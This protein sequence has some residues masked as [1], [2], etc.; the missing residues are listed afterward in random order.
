[1]DKIFPRV[2]RL[3]SKILTRNRLPGYRSHS[4]ELL[5]LGGVEYRVWNPN[6]S[7]PAAAIAKGLKTFPLKKGTKILYLGAANGNT[8][9]F[10]SDIVGMEGIIY[11]VEIS[12]RSMGDLNSLAIKRKNIIPVLANAKLPSSYNWVEKVD[13]LYQDVATSDQSEILIRNAKAFLKKGGCAMIAIKSR[14]IDVTKK[15]DIIYKQ[16]SEK[17]SKHFKLLE[18][19][20]LDPYEKD[21]CFFVMKS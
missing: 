7:K 8:V 11:A 15:P 2:F 17:L 10:F 1:M 21:H 19:K 16:E 20:K 3:G 18:K 13:V 4:E 5:E 14:S 6:R 12:E 9:S